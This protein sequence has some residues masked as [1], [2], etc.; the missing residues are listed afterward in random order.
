MLRVEY[1]D[2]L[3]LPDLDLWMDADGPRERC[4]ISHGHSDHIAEHRSIIATPET[5]RIFRHRRGDAEMETLRYGERRDYGRFALTFFPAGHC[6]GSAQV[7]IE[8]DGERLVYTGDIKLRPNVAAEDAVV[9]PC[10]TLVMEST[11]GDPLYR[12]PPDVVTAAR[13]YA[14]VDRALSDDR[15]PVVLA[16]ALGKGQEALELLLRRGL[17]V[18]LHGSVW[19]VA[20]IYR[21]M[22]VEF[23]GP[24]ERYDREHLRGRVLVA[25]PGC[26]RQAMITNIERR[27]VIMLTGWAMHRSARYMYRGVDLVLPLSD[28][29]DFDE[30]VHLARA[31]GA[32]RI[33]TMHGEPK[34]A[35]TLRELG[36]NAEHLAH[37]QGSAQAEKKRR[38]TKKTRDAEPLLFN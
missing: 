8:A 16:Y 4:V 7:L 20:E 25:P 24:Y 15:V 32:K 1:R 33:I 19:N 36:L 29:A 37:Y 3:Y 26:R 17:R 5:A 30:L 13:L 35:A 12:F 38:G 22:G 28:H 27:Y 23:S 21:E 11:F 18:T 14:A 9:V 6:L 34:F 31:S 10:D 2:G